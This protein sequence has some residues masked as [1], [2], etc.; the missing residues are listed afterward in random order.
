MSDDIN[1]RIIRARVALSNIMRAHNLSEAAALYRLRSDAPDH[2]SALCHEQLIAGAER[3]CPRYVADREETAVVAA[4]GKAQRGRTALAA[5]VRAAHAQRAAKADSR[6]AGRPA[7]PKAPS[8]A[9]ARPAGA[10][11]LAVPTAGRIKT[12]LHGS[13]VMPAPAT[14]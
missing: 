12:I 6:P 1:S 5:R 13:V 11:T 10:K 4:L 8:G 7:T 3:R 14:K 9:P 2:Y